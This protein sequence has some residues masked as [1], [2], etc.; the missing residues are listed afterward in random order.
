MNNKICFF[1]TRLFIGLIFLL[2]FVSAPFIPK[3]HYR[4]IECRCQK[5]RCQ[6]CECDTHKPYNYITNQI[7]E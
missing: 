2:C 3:V 6:N 7:K 4:T 5:C 1:K